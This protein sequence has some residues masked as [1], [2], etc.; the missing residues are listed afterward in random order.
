MARRARVGLRLGTGERI[1][2]GMLYKSL[3]SFRIAKKVK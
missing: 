1:N 2:E 3:E